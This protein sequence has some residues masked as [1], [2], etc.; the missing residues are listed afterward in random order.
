[1]TTQRKVSLFL[2][3]AA[4]VLSVSG[5]G[6][7]SSGSSSPP[8]VHNE[9]TWK[10]GSSAADQPGSYGNLGTASPSDIPGGR[11]YPS[12]WTDAA[13]NFWLFGGY[14]FASSSGTDGDLNDLWEFSDGEWKWVSGSNQI[15]QKGSY[16]TE[17]V[18][19]ATNVP[20][21][22]YWAE[23]WT[24][25][26]GDL[27]LFG[28][29]GWDSQGLRGYLND[30]WK[31]SNGEWTWMSG[32]DIEAQGDG[33]TSL[34][35]GVYGTKGVANPANTPGARVDA[36]AWSDAAGDLWLFG[37]TGADDGTHGFGV[38][39]DLWKYNPSL[40]QWTWMAGSSIADQVG[41]YGTLGTPSPANTPGA[42]FGA[43]TW[44]DAAGNLW[45]FGGVGNDVNGQC[46]GTAPPCELDDLWEY[47]PSL[48]EWTWMG[49]PDV[50]NV[51]G[52]YGT[53]GVPSPSNLPPPRD[54]A[55][56]W[57]DS[58]GNFWLFG[59]DSPYNMNDLWK[60]DPSTREWTW[61]SGSTGTNGAGVYGTL[62]VPAPA[63]TPGCRDGSAAWTDRS[64]NLWLFAGEADTCTGNAKFNDLW[65]YTP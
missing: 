42:R 2:L 60:Y 38:L 30:L 50:G 32:P 47:S 19:S 13:G 39:N 7:N 59:G 11:T 49:G 22:R 44:T 62:G 53:K 31:Y 52:V 61:M 24:G 1:M 54:N 12:S 58:A 35:T 29:L 10:G 34:G 23:S 16:G 15:N 46:R 25:K 18:A 8:P 4:A 21:S 17:G 45:L 64:G 55:I 9:W 14:G 43:A 6:S 28:G 27:W 40:N 63:N 36:S 3:A 65:E 48:N 56:T 33:S 51:A 5:C 41:V 26:S 57:V 20:G 37:G